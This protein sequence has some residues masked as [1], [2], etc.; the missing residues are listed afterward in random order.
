MRLVRVI[1]VGLAAFLSACGAPDSEPTTADAG[2][3]FAGPSSQGARSSSATPSGSASA[4]STSGVSAG[5]SSGGSAGPSSTAGSSSSAP[6]SS[7]AS[8]AS[9]ASVAPLPVGPWA[10]QNCATDGATAAPGQHPFAPLPAP[11]VSLHDVDADLMALLEGG[12][13]RDA[14]E[15][16]EAQPEDA[17][18]K[19]L[20]GKSMFFHEGFGTPGMPGG[21]VDFMMQNFPDEVGP[22]FTRMG[23]VADPTS[24]RGLPLGLTETPLPQAGSVAYS[25]ASCHFGQMPDGRY[26]VGFPNHAYDY[27]G[28]LLAVSVFPSLVNPAGGTQG[29]DPLAVA[30]LQPMVDRYR[31]DGGLRLRFTGVL[32]GLLGLLG[33]QP[34]ITTVEENAM[35]RWKTGTQDFMM[36]P[37]PVDDH[38][39]TVHRM[40][41]LWGIPTTQVAAQAGMPHAQLGWSGGTRSLMY[42]LRSFVTS[43]GGDLTAWPDHRLEPLAAYLESLRAPANPQPA[44]PSQVTRGCQVFEAAGCLACHSGVGGG[45]T[46]TYTLAEVGT[47]PALARWMDADGDGV[48]C[49][50]VN[51]PDFELTGEVKAPRM[52]GMWSFSRFLHNGALDSLEQLL[53][54]APRPADTEAPFSA[55]GH[56]YGCDGV[57]ADDRAALLA[58]LRAH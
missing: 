57:S 19:L 37:T 29:H 4:S 38:I 24:T 36:A 58:Y 8:P 54:V 40:S 11:P 25:C 35:A 1:T 56:R 33:S 16:W 3:S 34:A 26:A 44:A 50:G 47:D 21:L 7:S 20:C 41:P 39:H 32:I 12:T 49:C 55:Q 48:N 27:G 15:A 9:S 2:S 13:L 6:R 28:Q 52:W 22:A 30:R 10:Q 5:S 42:F 53:C 17:R 14:C 45:S 51:D 18:L 23:M 31:A 46:R 43:G